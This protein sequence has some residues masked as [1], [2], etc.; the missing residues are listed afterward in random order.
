MNLHNEWLEGKLCEKG[1]MKE[2]FD[3]E[4]DDLVRELTAEGKIKVR[5]LIKQDPSFFISVAKDVEKELPLEF[6]DKFWGE[7]YNEIRKRN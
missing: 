7:V 1:L 4:K 2:R 3:L 5:G 6:R